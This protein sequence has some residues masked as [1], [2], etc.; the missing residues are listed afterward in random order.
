MR[1]D[2]VKIYSSFRPSLKPKEQKNVVILEA[3]VLKRLK[4]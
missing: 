3:K 2:K 4:K 1:R